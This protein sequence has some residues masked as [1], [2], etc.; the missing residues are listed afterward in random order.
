LDHADIWATKSE[1]SEERYVDIQVGGCLYQA[2]ND[3][4]ARGGNIE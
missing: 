4:F 1:Q 3:T 2:I